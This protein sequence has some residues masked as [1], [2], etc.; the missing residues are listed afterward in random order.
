MKHKRKRAKKHLAEA[1]QN[2]RIMQD[3]ETKIKGVE[4]IE[5]DARGASDRLASELVKAETLLSKKDEDAV[6]MK[7]EYNTLQ[8]ANEHLTSQLSI[9]AKGYLEKEASIGV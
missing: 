6:A 2:K 1:S 7:A 9:K 3:A 8:S 4:A 5:R